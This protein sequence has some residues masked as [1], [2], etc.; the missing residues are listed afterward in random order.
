MKVALGIEYSGENYCGWQRQSHSPSVQ[1]PLEN[2]LSIIAD[3]PIRVF[4]AGRTDTGVHATGQVIHFELNCIRPETAWLR[5][6]NNKLPS[7]ISVVWAKSVHE[8]FHAR[9]SAEKRS[10]R[11]IIQNIDFPAASLAKKVTW[12]RRGLDCKLM[13]LGANYLV[14]RHDFSSFRA[15]SC[16]A[17][18]AIRTIAYVRVNQHNDLIFV[19]V[20]ANAFLHHMVRNI[21]GC[22]LRVGE[23]AEPP[24]FVERILRIK[25]RTRAPD[26]A[27]PHGLYLVGVDYP[28]RD[29]IPCSPFYPLGHQVAISS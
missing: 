5:G 1:E 27:K 20:K 16:Q 22:L 7:D 6:A 4:C 28:S 13:Q 2:A 17:N 24:D 10:Y 19:D 26:T 21:V 12:H 14:G 9:F 18:T 15:S 11:Y 8:D 23:G 29:K 3:E 25:D